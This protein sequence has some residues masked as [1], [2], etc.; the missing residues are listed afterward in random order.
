M[1]GY[2]RLDAFRATPLVKEPFEHLIVSGF[3][4]PAGLAA[5]NADYPNITTSG[6]FPVDQVSFR[7]AFRRCSTNS[8]A[9]RSVKPSSRNSASIFRTGRP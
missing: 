9:T 7:P 8:R 6:S 4:D 3:V 5:I 2:L 1:P